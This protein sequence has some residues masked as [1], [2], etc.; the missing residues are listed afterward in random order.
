M[1][2]VIDTPRGPFMLAR[3]CNGC[4]L[5][6]KVMIAEE[7]INKP[8]G[9]WCEH[10]TPGKGCGIH[11]KR[12]PVCSEFYCVWLMDPTL[13]EEWHPETCHM[14]LSLDLDGMRFNAHCDQDFP[15]AWRAEPYY[16]QMKAKAAYA[17]PLRGQV[18]AYSRRNV[19]VMLPD[20]HV[21]LG[22]LTD[23][24]YI[25]IEDLGEGAWDARKV[26]DAEVAELRE[27]GK[28]P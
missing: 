19:I 3:S 4:T 20:R 14:V 21:E 11:L 17:L 8:A 25:F 5:C 2:L 23:G 10:C 15:D 26:N 12:P 13:G 22:I 27:A 9:V 18:V 7:P 16:S 28:L 24:E 6:C 1:S